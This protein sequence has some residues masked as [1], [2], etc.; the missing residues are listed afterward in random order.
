M[1]PLGY[2]SFEISIAQPRPVHFEVGGPAGAYMCC[3]HR[4]GVW[5]DNGRGR[6]VTSANRNL[7]SSSMEHK[8]RSS[9][10]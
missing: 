4:I 1:P 10:D 6:D 8:K 9:R 7:A 2:V 5:S 3:D